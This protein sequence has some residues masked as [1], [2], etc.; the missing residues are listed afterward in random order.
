MLA[1]DLISIDI[2]PLKVGDEAKKALEWMD[3]F[4]VSHLPVID[5]THYIGLVS[6]AEILD[7]ISATDH[8]SKIRRTLTKPFVFEH[9]HAYDVLKMYSL[10]KISV[11]PIIDAKEHYVGVVTM[12]KMLDYFAQ[13]TA[14]QEPGS[15]IVLELHQHDYSLSQ[16]AQIAESNGAKILSLFLTPRENSTELNVTLKLSVQDVSAVLQTFERFGYTVTASFSQTI[17]NTG[18]KDRYDALM[19]YLNI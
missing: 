14:A 6:D 8:I 15:L 18:I 2:P 9:Q 10:L 5:K 12:Q 7:H 3:E 13:L 1:K 19:H 16:I 11:I 4:K 17:Q